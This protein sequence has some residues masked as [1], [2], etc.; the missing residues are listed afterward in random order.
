M[1]E[2]ADMYVDTNWSQLEEALAAAKEVYNDGD[3]M[4]DDIEP[5]AEA[6][7]NAIMAQRYQADKSILNDLVNK[8]N[9]MDMSGYTAESVAV[10]KA[11]LYN[12]NLVLADES[13]SEDDQAVVDE[14]VAEL[15]EAIEN[16]SADTSEPSTDDGKDDGSS[17]EDTNSSN[18]DD[19]SKPDSTT[20]D[21]DTS[22]G[23]STTSTTSKDDSAAETVPTTGDNSV[24]PLFAVAAVV[25]AGLGLV[26]LKKKE[27]A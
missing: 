19:T 5:A 4:D 3:A 11:A 10:F 23:D 15:N 12:A 26:V 21:T 2:N 13:L 24:L 16:L 6:L 18:N 14:A 20:S 17:T 7:L 27:N 8:A 22:K 9:E 1:V 25:T